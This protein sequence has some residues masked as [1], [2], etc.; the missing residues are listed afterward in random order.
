MEKIENV[1]YYLINKSV[2]MA[3]SYLN[4]NYLLSYEK[5]LG[6]ILLA[7]SEHMQT[8]S[9]NLVNEDIYY[10]SVGL[11]IKDGD[12][13]YN[14]KAFD[15]A[16]QELRMKLLPYESRDDIP[17]YDKKGFEVSS[18]MDMKA[19]TI[20]EDVYIRFGELSERT[21]KSY[22]EIIFAEGKQNKNYFLISKDELKKLP[23]QINSESINVITTQMGSIK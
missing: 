2:D 14:N 8:Y 5:L 20:L 16:N 18:E 23:L 15:T 6:L 11:R 10:T 9:E 12:T 13:A 1:S 4:N 17:V 3:N 22:I 21:I 19:R 7:Q